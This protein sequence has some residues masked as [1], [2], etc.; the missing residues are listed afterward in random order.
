MP[1]L[2]PTI[3]HGFPA[4]LEKELIVD[5]GLFWDARDVRDLGMNDLV[6]EVEKIR[7]KLP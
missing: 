6:K 2:V 7:D 5:I 3:A 4:T 1:D